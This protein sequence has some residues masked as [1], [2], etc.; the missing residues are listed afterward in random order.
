MR[1]APSYAD[2]LVA[3]SSKK[4]RLPRGWAA[5]LLQVLRHQ[6]G[7]SRKT[8]LVKGCALR[9]G[10]VGY[11][12]NPVPQ[13]LRIVSYFKDRVLRFLKRIDPP[14]RSS[15]SQENFAP[16]RH[17]PRQH[18]PGNRPRRLPLGVQGK[19]L[20][21]QFSGTFT[22]RHSLESVPFRP[23]GPQREPLAGDSKG[24]IAR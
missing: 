15:K 10:E 8:I 5:F 16:P 1:Q 14:P 22:D 19:S 20:T 24:P 9:A 4:Q 18:S 2:A 17:P 11:Q 23:V 3:G 6:G 12:R 7:V 21:C 13:V